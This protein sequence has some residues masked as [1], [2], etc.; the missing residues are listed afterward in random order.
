MTS[1]LPDSMTLGEAR[2]WLR[3]QLKDGA[4]CPCCTQHA[5]VYRWSLYSTAVRA[6]AF[7]ARLGQHNEGGWV[8]TTEIKK[9]GH[10]GQGDASRLLHWGLVERDPNDRPDGGRS[11]YWRITQRGADFLYGRT[12]I[13]KYV[14]VFDGRVLGMDG[15]H[16][17]VRDVIGTKFSYEEMMAGGPMPM[18]RVERALL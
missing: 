10:R 7:Y 4:A 1:K 9:A 11:G 8:H 17:S 6:L 3:S 15:D 18:E 13:P 5:Q 12:T 16:V 14:Y 2:Q